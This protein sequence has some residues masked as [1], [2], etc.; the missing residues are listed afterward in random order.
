MKKLILLISV[1]ILTGCVF[2]PYRNSKYGD[3]AVKSWFNDETLGEKRKQIENI[4]QIVSSD[5]N[6]L[7][8]SN[9][10]YVFLCNVEYTAKGETVIPLSK[11][12]NIDL[13]VVFIKKAGN[14]YD[15]KV[16][17]STSKEGVWKLDE[18]LDY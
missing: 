10:K 13:Y 8:H 11:H 18:Y 1:F 6:Y 4:D 14:K 3:I 5:C 15:S 7:E 9:N 12:S 2:S 16:Y 17:N